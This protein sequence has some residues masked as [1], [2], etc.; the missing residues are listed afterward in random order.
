MTIGV[1][2]TLT[3]QRRATRGCAEDEREHE[4]EMY[5]QLNAEVGY[6]RSLVGPRGSL[7]DEVQRAFLALSARPAL[8]RPL[9][10]AMSHAFRAARAV[11]RSVRRERG[12]AR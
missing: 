5:E 10:A 1:L 7:P 3:G 8:S 4:R 2:Q 12:G 11:A 9:Y 6:G